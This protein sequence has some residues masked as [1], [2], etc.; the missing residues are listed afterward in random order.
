MD[1]L[2]VRALA[3]CEQSLS[4]D[5]FEIEAQSTSMI[6]MKIQMVQV[7]KVITDEIKNWRVGSGVVV[8]GAERNQ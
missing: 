4:K 2:A 1:G 6:L 3:K 5:E 7:L 8:K